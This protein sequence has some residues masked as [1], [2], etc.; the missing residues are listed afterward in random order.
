VE[1]HV[2]QRR[3][4]PAVPANQIGEVNA[5]L[6]SLIPPGSRTSRCTATRRRPST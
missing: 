2:L 1:P 3:R 6:L 4:G 5:N